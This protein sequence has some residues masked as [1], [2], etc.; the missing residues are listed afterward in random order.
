MLK[1]DSVLQKKKSQ[2]LIKTKNQ[3]VVKN[4]LVGAVSDSDSS[5]QTLKLK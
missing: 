4:Y 2:G 3:K 5:Q 1:A